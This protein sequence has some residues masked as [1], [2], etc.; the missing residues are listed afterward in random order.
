MPCDRCEKP[1]VTYQSHR[2]VLQDDGTRR[3]EHLHLCA[4]CAQAEERTQEAV[5]RAIQ[6]DVARRIA[7][8]SLIQELRADLKPIVAS[9]DLAQIAQ[10]AEFLALIAT[11][12]PDGLPPDLHEIVVQHH[13]P[14]LEARETL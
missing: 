5:A 8:G 4:V 3:D 12:L 7:D 13:R 1:V 9:G 14:S 11:G 6:A 10:A 2:V